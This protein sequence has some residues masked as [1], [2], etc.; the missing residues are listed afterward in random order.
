MDIG[1]DEGHPQRDP[2]LIHMQMSLAATASPIGRIASQRLVLQTDRL[3]SH[4]RLHQH[5]VYGLPSPS[6]LMKRLVVFGLQAENLGKHA[7]A[8][9]VLKVR[10]DR[11]FGPMARWKIVPLTA[12][13]QDV[14]DAV[15]DAP[16]V[17]GRAA[18]RFFSA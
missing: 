12:G 7:S 10:V 16:D 9:P 5:P 11:A 3:T 8:Y 6:N 13:L 4:R 1:P 17:Q 14:E 2:V 18:T 15:Q